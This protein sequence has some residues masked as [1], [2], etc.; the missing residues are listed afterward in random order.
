LAWTMPAR[1]RCCTCS[2]TSASRS[3]TRRSI[4][5]RALPDSG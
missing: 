4:R 1:R 2:R 5:V 3:T